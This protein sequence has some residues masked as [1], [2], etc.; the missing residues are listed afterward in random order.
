MS[1]PR[2]N[3]QKESLEDLLD[4]LN[5]AGSEPSARVSV[6]DILDAIGYRSFGPLLLVIGLLTLSPLGDIPGTPT[7]MAVLLILI[8]GQ[9]LMKR[10]SIWLP[11]W[12][13][14]RSVS[15]KKFQTSLG[16]MRRP[17]QFADHWLRPRLTILTA[18]AARYA[19]A[20]VCLVIALAMPPMELMP[21]TATT[22]GIALSCFG[23][24]LTLDDGLMVVV[25]FAFI[26]ITAAIAIYLSL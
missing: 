12:L 4:W 25:A 3:H 11:R 23:L 10:K 9:L 26:A 1:K 2:Q 16:W 6:G 15:Q 5:A 7:V 13:L 14:K 8:T 18:G 19:I 21:F 22:A 17:A 20:S 24:A